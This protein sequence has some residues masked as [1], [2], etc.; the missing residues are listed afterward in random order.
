MLCLELILTQKCTVVVINSRK[1]TQKYMGATG[2]K[3]S[4]NSGH[5]WVVGVK[6]LNQIAS[7]LTYSFNMEF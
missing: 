6:G 4:I 2:F 5:K 3:G 1:L 7:Q